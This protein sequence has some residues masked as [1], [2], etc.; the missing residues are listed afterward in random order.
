MKE[1]QNRLIIDGVTATS[2]VSPF[3]GRGVD[4]FCDDSACKLVAAYD[5][6]IKGRDTEGCHSH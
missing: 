3:F 5:S 1:S 2:L 4:H 6:K